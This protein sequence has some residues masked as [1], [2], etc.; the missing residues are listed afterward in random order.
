MIPD[1]TSDIR[2]RK[3]VGERVRQFRLARG[4]SQQDLAKAVGYETFQAIALAERG[5][6]AIKVEILA[7]VAAVLQVTIDEFFPNEKTDRSD[8]AHVK[9]RASCADK[10][11]ERA[12]KDFASAAQR[13]FGKK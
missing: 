6:R 2:I 3:Y 12:L 11:V 1:N 8:V 9:L 10:D 4:I 13:K 7:R 5:E